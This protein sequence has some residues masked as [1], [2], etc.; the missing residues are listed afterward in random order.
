MRPF[1]KIHDLLV[2]RVVVTTVLLVWAVLVGLDAVLA[3]V[4]EVGNMGEGDYGFVSVLTYV[5]YTLPRRAYTMFPTA[6]VIGTLMGLGQL[7]ASS[8]LTALRAL[9]VSRRRLSV[10]V[11]V[12]LALL[13]GI[14]MLSGETLG[15]GAQRSADAMRTA[16]RSSDMIVARY[17][18]LWA[19][20]GNIFL[21][22]RDGRERSEGGEA[23]LELDDV[24]LFE[25]DGGGR[26]ASVAQVGRAEHRSS[27]WLLRDVRRMTFE[28]RSVAEVHIDEEHWESQLD[29]AALAA[30][31]GAFRPR[32]MSARELAES[33]DYRH[34]NRLDASEFEEHYWGRWYYPVNVLALCLAAMPFAFGSL[35]S[36]GLGRRLF[37]GV[38]FALGF[39]MLQNQVAKLAAVYG[40]DYRLAYAVPPLL[41]LTVSWL[42]FRRR[43]G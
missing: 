11:A 25:F 10:S 24:R 37:I 38:V 1:P 23:W 35:R 9:G 34:R 27:G 7:A 22:A 4:D 39:W 19:R 42:L 41:M 14:M 16:A 28:E 5:A 29:A 33:I 15:P 31:A 3:A 26:L 6:A 30:S 43:S 36:G 12:P 40:F 2:A 20:E 21:N 13:T 32:Y 18:G 8:E 17:S